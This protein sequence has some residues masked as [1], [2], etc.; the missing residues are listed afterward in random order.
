[1]VA[2]ADRL[3]QF[4]QLVGMRDDAVRRLGDRV[5]KHVPAVSHDDPLQAAIRRPDRSKNNGPRMLIRTPS[6]TFKGDSG[7]A[8][9]TSL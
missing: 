9:V 4:R 5:Y 7:S 8:R 6:P 3:I 1:M 2:V